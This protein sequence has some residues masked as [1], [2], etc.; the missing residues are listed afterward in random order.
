MITIRGLLACGFLFVLGGCASTPCVAPDK[1]SKDPPI[2]CY[3]QLKV[4]KKHPDSIRGKVPNVLVIEYEDDYKH[5]DET[6]EFTKPKSEKSEN[7]YTFRVSH[8]EKLSDLI[9]EGRT[10]EFMRVGNYPELGL[11]KEIV[12]KQAK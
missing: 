3:Y 1:L 10:Y 6:I 9:V 12:P 4:I 5:K 7:E 8:F 2:T 11:G